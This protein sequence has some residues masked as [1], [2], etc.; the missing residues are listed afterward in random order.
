M[1]EGY[2]EVEELNKMGITKIGEDVLISRKASLYMT[3]RMEFGNH[4]RV[5]DFCHLSGQIKIG[6]NVH[7]A[8]YTNLV[9]GNAGIVMED[10]SGASAKVSVYAVSDDYSG[11]TMTNP[12]VPSEFKE[13]IEKSVT[14]KRHSII[15][16]GSVILPGVVLEEGTACGAMS[17][18]N[19]STL[20]WGIYVGIPCKRVGER[21][22]DLLDLE[23]Q[24][25]EYLN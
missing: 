13:C 11:R 12:T 4:V 15:G 25:R 20:P 8:P 5:D 17:L 22:K 24:Y 2:Y 6:N 23:K 1:L 9:G 3:D 21:K 18:V 7:I 14:I 10:F 16:V 19:K